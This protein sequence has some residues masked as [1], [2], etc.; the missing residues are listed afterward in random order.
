MK[1]RTHKERSKALFGASAASALAWSLAMT[2]ALAAS[3]DISTSPLFTSSPTAVKP[4]IMFILD[5]SG[6]M[7]DENMPD[8]APSSVAR[9]GYK[10]AQCN[11]LAFNPAITYVLPINSDGS[12]KAAGTFPALA[13][14]SSQTSVSPSSVAYV[15]NGSTTVTLTVSG[16]GTFGNGQGVTLYDT[17]S[18]DAN[19]MTGTVT[20]WD[21]VNKTLNITVSASSGSGT[22]SNL[23]LASG[24]PSFYY[25]YSGSQSPMSYTFN[26]TG[27]DRT[28]TFYKE[29]ISSVGASPGS[30]VFA[31]VNITSTSAAAQNYANWYTYYSTRMLM[32][33]SS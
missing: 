8:D 19:W 4:N 13:N 25:T 18:S 10:A 16:G 30:G 27:A 12:S 1:I 7:A 33:K 14:L 32:M 26:G 15:S 6:S 24:A 20:N 17:T 9:Y 5:D 23:K 2:P 29:C 3:T 28:T 21:K 11:G 22:L 31:Q